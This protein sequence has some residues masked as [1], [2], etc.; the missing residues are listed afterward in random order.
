MVKARK[1]LVDMNKEEKIMKL[2]KAE[3]KTRHLKHLL[4]TE[5]IH[6]RRM[7]ENHEK[8]LEYI[9]KLSKQLKECL[10]QLNRG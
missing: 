4:E 9:Q 1:D 5:T 7:M 6:L 2:E 3:Q 10:K 8:R